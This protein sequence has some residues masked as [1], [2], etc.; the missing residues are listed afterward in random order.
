MI[1]IKEKNRDAIEE[2]KKGS[3]KNMYNEKEARLKM[4][5]II[6]IIIVKIKISD[7]LSPTENMSFFANRTNMVQSIS[8]FNSSGN[9]SNNLAAE[10]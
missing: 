6:I 7:T 9:V 8:S 3:I 1:F 10:S 2:E 4:I 5:I